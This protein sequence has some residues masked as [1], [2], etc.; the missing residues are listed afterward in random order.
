MRVLF[1][2]PHYTHDPQTLLLHPPLGYAYMARSLNRGG[3]EVV[4]VDLPFEGNS[5]A[6]L[7]RRLDELRPDLVGV[8]SVAQS[9]F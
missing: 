1:V 5:A 9:Y 7:I 4:H 2:N 3:H 6:A 8:T